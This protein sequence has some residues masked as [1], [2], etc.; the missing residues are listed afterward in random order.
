MGSECLNEFG[1]IDRDRTV[2]D[3]VRHA[4]SAKARQDPERNQKHGIDGANNLKQCS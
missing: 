3:I 2:H 4:V 1:S